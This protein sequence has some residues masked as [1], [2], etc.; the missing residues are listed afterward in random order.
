MTKSM[1]SSSTFKVVSLAIGSKHIPHM[2]VKVTSPNA[3]LR[4]KLNCCKKNVL[5]ADKVETCPR[6]ENWSRL[7]LS[8][9][10]KCHTL[11]MR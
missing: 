1:I 2:R 4:L 3:R 5:D 11:C 7:T 9:P 10:F 8:N 6:A